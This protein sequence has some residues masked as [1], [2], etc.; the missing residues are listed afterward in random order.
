MLGTGAA[1]QCDGA[2]AVSRPCPRGAGG[3]AGADPWGFCTCAVACRSRRTAHLRGV[4]LN[5]WEDRPLTLMTYVLD[6]LLPGTGS[7]RLPA[8]SRCR[9]VGA[10]WTV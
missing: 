2:V 5:D 6:R 9:K 10:A 4:A 1:A 3:L 8:C 7:R